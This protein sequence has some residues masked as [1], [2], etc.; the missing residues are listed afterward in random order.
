M[1]SNRRLTGVPSGFS[2]SVAGIRGSKLEDIICVAGIRTLGRQ[3]CYA[4]VT[5]NRERQ[6]ATFA[7]NADATQETVCRRHSF[8]LLIAWKLPLRRHTLLP[9]FYRPTRIGVP[10]W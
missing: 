7:A 1:S 8:P 4:C 6:P 3:A 2:S 9:L 5:Y 10:T